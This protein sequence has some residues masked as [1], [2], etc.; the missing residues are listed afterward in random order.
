MTEPSPE[1]TTAT[2]SIRPLIPEVAPLLV[3]MTFPAYRH[4]ME[5]APAPRHLDDTT[6]RPIQPIAFAAWVGPKP[7]GVA[8]AETPLDGPASGVDPEILSIFV[9]Q[10]WRSQGVATQLVAATEDA[11]RELG[12]P[13][14]AAV[15]MTGRPSIP[16]IEHILQQRGWLPPATRTI[17]VRFTPE[18]AARTPWFQRVKLPDRFEIV[19]WS[20]ITAEERAEIR[21]SHEA[22]SW[23][24]RGLEPWTH[25]YYGFDPI[26]S[27]GL[28][29]GGAV[30]G[31]VINHRISE[32]CVRFTCSFMRRDLSRRG[33]ILPL[34]TES[35]LRLSAAGI[36]EC[37]L[38]TPLEYGE[39]AEFLRRRCASAVH[40][41]GETRGSLKRLS[42]TER[43]RS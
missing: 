26:S 3:S 19:P 16:V 31:W 21:R 33:R 40:Y 43:E 30:V 7:V 12:Y 17:S 34:Y 27:L 8:L 35:I 14:L 32:D 10:D 18:E 6:Q 11:V 28:R 1:P 20:E 36:K 9:L 22:A 4:L 39:M 24:A 38:V 42:D 23:I 15:W 13:R 5:L 25:D 29:Y 2:I 37:T 41:F